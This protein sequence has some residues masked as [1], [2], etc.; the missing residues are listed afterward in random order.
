MPYY[1]RIFFIYF[2]LGTAT[3]LRAQSQPPDNLENLKIVIIRHAEKPLKG[4]NLNCQGLNRSVV[5]PKMITAKFGVPDFTY[6]PKM[7]H[8]SSTRHSRMF[9]TIIPLAV[10]YNLII[11]S[12]FAEKDSAELA[13]DIKSRSGTVLVIW[14]HRA[15]TPIVRALGLQD[16]MQIWGDD[17]YDSIW[18]IRFQKGI[19]KISFDKEGLHPAE[20]C[21]F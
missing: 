15:I 20:A 17:D 5:L 12:R 13:T 11:N 8:D 19:A 6:V 1:F 9:Q 4:D 14:E 18:I 10:K 16:F 7:G 2:L 3:C 21:R